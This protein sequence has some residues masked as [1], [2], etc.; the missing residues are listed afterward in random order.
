MRTE[1]LVEVANPSELFLADYGRAGSGSVVVPTME[2]SR[3]LLVEIQSLVSRANF[4]TPERKTSGV[5][6]NRVA[7]LLAVLER[8]GGLPL[9][10]QDT[11][12]NVVGGVQVLEPA[13]D[14]GIALAVASSFRDMP[15]PRGAVAFGE[16]GLGGEIRAVPRAEFRLR[17]AW[18]M[19]FTCAIVPKGVSKNVPSP[20]KGKK[21]VEASTVAD[22]LGA[23]LAPK[24]AE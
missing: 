15:L 23:L 11:F 12:V 20:G 24:R 21:L 3:T 9:G 10:T 5:D 4:G 14:L 19:G 13:A 8:R 18:K 22:A 7:M 1:G 17:E 16:V 6:R 2:G